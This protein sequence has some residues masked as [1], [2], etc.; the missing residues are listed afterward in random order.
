MSKREISCMCPLECDC[1][2]P[3]PEDGGVAYVSNGCPIHNERPYPNPECRAHTH[4]DDNEAWVAA[5][6]ILNR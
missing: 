6:E 3:E 4:F 5:W 2:N 1:E